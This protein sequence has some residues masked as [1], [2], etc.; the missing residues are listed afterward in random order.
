MYIEIIRQINAELLAAFDRLMPQLSAAAPPTTD[1]LAE[2]FST[3]GVFLFVARQPGKDGQIVGL[4]TLATL[5]VPSGKRAWI[6]DVVVDEAARGQGIGEALV[7]AALAQAAE[8]GAKSV[9]LTSRPARQA[10]NRLYQRLG[11]V[12]PGTNFYRYTFEA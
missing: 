6:E 9:E 7:R 2:M 8:V 3:P 4:L 1:D 5:R 12:Q 10:A 11:F